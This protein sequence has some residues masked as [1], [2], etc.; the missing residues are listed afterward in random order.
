MPFVAD[1]EVRDHPEHP[2]LFLFLDLHVRHFL[3]RESNVH[4]CYLGGDHQHDQRSNVGFS[5]LQSPGELL[6]RE[7]R[8]RNCELERAGN[9]IG[10]RE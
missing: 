10:K 2:L 5:R 7:A 3:W 8:R 9:E 6:R 1:I 4:L